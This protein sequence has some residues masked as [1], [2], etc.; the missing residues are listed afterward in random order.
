MWVRAQYENMYLFLYKDEQCHLTTLDSE[1]SLTQ[2][3]EGVKEMCRK[4]AQMCR[5][6]DVE[7][8]Q[9]LGDV[10]Q[11]T[12]L[13]LMPKSQPVKTD[14]I[15]RDGPLPVS[16]PEDDGRIFGADRHTV[17]I[18][19]RWTWPAH[20]KRILCKDA[21]MSDT[22][23]IFDANKIFFLFSLKKNK[24]YILFTKKYPVGRVGVFLDYD[25]GAVSFYDFHHSFPIHS[26]SYEPFSVLLAFGQEPLFVYGNQ[27]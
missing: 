27:S 2:Q 18:T 14:L 21:G 9:D 4:L 15:S 1:I 16:L 7:L 8:L 5:K 17:S 24:Q 25:C 12:E 3:T 13:V 6:P 10:F 19:K 23:N 11:R 26:V 22:D 20:S